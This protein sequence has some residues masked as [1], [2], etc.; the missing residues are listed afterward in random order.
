M[1]LRIA[2]ASG[3]RASGH[4]LGEMLRAKGVI[5]ED[6]KPIAVV[7]YGVPMAPSRWVLNAR[8][9]MDKLTELRTLKAGGVQVPEFTQDPED[10]DGLWYA[11]KL[12]HVRGRDLIPVTQKDEA[13]WR[14]AAGWHYFTKRVPIRRELRTWMFR[15]RHLGTYV[16]EM[17]DPTKFTKLGRGHGNGF[18]FNRFK[19]PPQSLRL[20]ADSA[21]T[22]LGLDFGAVDIIEQGEGI[23]TVLEVNTAPGIEHERRTC[24]KRLV[25][26]IVKWYRG[27]T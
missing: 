20:V 5:A 15:G 11:R 12:D 2:I 8:P 10:I 25:T 6:G 13:A 4:I 22:A 23:Y 1:T 27:L 14:L 18:S 21:L 16:K 24:A 7:S 17:A 3:A 26:E 9:A 19:D